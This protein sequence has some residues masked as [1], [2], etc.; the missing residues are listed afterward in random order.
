ML[1]GNH[2]IDFQHRVRQCNACMLCQ[3][4]IEHFI[5]A[6]FRPA[7]LQIGLTRQTLKRGRK[8]IKGSG[9]DQVHGKA[10]CDADCDSA[11][12]DECT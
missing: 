5:E 2:G 9:I 11:D 4:R 3:H 12:G 8:F 10:K 1:A 6:G 7:H